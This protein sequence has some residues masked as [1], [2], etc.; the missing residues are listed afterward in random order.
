MN[1][2]ICK[3][4]SHRNESETKNSLS[5]VGTEIKQNDVHACAVRAALTRLQIKL[6]HQ[7]IY[8]NPNQQRSRISGG[9]NSPRHMGEKK[10]KV[11]ILSRT[12]QNPLVNNTGTK[13]GKIAA[14]KKS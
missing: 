3:T 1:K 10:S 6:K 14:Y 9:K 11:I 8:F 13:E 4:N 12:Q 7:Q 5:F 2:T